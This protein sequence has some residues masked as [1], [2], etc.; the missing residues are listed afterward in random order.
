M[1]SPSTIL[2]EGLSEFNR[3]IGWSLGD[4]HFVPAVFFDSLEAIQF[5]SN[6]FQHTAYRSFAVGDK[7]EGSL[8]VNPIFMERAT[9]VGVAIETSQRELVGAEEELRTTIASDDV[10]HTQPDE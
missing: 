8:V 9:L 2:V 7:K 1:E 4:I 5:K 3:R 6:D 10:S